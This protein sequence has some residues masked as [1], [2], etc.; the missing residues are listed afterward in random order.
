MSS[1]IFRTPTTKNDG[2]RYCGEAALCHNELRVVQAFLPVLFFRPAILGPMAKPD[3]PNFSLPV[4][5][6]FGVIAL[7][8]IVALLGFFGYLR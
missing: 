3:R 4:R 7:V 1:V 6:I 8:M 5:I 2:P